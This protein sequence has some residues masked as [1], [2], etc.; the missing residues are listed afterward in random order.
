MEKETLIEYITEKLVEETKNISIELI[1]SIFVK[2]QEVRENNIALLELDSD[3]EYLRKEKILNKGEK[4]SEHELR[5]ILGYLLDYRI[6][7]DWY[8]EIYDRYLKQNR[9]RDMYIHQTPTII[10]LISTKIL[11]DIS[12]LTVYDGCAGIGTTIEELIKNNENLKV[13]C[14]EV[15]V[16]S[17]TI[18]ITKL[19]LLKANY[20]T[21]LDSLLKDPKFIKKNAFDIAVIDWPFGMTFQ[22]EELEEIKKRPD[23]YIHGIPSQA[24][25]ILLI[26]QQ[27]L[28]ALKE[29]GKAI[30]VT[31][32]GILDKKGKDEKVRKSIISMD[33]IETIIE[34][35][36]KIY[37]PYTSISASLII[38]NKSKEKNKNIQFID[39]SNINIENLKTE[40]ETTRYIDKIIDI[41]KSKKEEPGFSSN[42]DLIDLENSKLGCKNYISIG[43]QEI[44]TSYFENVMINEKEVKELLKKPHKKLKDIATLYRGINILKSENTPQGK[45]KVLNMSALK[46]GNIDYEDYIQSNLERFTNIEKSIIKEGDILISCKGEGIKIA[47]V[48]KNIK[49]YAITQSS[50]TIRPTDEIDSEYLKLYLDSPLG[51]YLISKIQK[52]AFI[53]MISIKDLENL[54]IILPQYD[55]QLEISKEFQKKQTEIEEQM[56]ELMNKQ[57]EN[58]ME[59]YKNMN[60]EKTFKL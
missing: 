27:V 21:D 5:N 17:L 45:Y 7:P 31:P 1:S 41:Y 23:I 12:N 26:I 55:E 16:M 10:N 54:D 56:K 57:K 13:L 38:I 9:T 40:E 33:V 3:S 22:A 60:I 47:L 30:F 35:P 6:E 51:R 42:V 18:L 29:N 49:D 25:S 43:K 19:N 28:Y 50:I 4:V 8:I 34:L 44:K 58:R 46:D 32:T 15:N 53:P 52:G 48:N 37:H 59:L 14:Q 39:A 20:E 36:K 24:S 2:A 11:G